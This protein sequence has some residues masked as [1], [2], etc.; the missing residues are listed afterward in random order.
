MWRFS[1]PRPDPPPPSNVVRH[2]QH[3]EL[4]LYASITF[5][6]PTTKTFYQAVVNGRLTNYPTLTAEMIRKTSLTA[7]QLP[8]TTSPL[9]SPASDLLRQRTRNL[10]RSPPKP[11]SNPNALDHK[12]SAD[13]PHNCRPK[14]NT[15]DGE[16]PAHQPTAHQLQSHQTPTT[17][18]NDAVQYGSPASIT[19][20]LSHY[21][22]SELPT[23]TLQRL[24]SRC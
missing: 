9:L 1:L 18:I 4:V 22:P 3:A 23:A 10:A 5:G 6:S 11:A 19:G 2:E 12:P 7:P 20:N 13:Q 21:K 14:F 15:S 17:Y 16:Q 24:V 8:W